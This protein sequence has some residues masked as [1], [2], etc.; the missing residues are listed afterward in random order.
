M[1]IVATSPKFHEIPQVYRLCDLGR[2]GRHMAT[3]KDKV[4]I[5]VRDYRDETRMSYTLEFVPSNC[6]GHEGLRMDWTDNYWD[7]GDYCFIPA[8]VDDLVLGDILSYCDYSA[9]AG[10][11]A[12]RH[13]GIDD[14]SL[15]EVVRE[16]LEALA[17]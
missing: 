15:E 6:R 7:C 13:A 1:S 2:F 12:L 8:D 16:V 17:A 3:T 14:G 9:D 4:T 5:L 10:R 11:N